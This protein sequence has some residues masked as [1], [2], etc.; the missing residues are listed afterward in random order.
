MDRPDDSPQT[1]IVTLTVEKLQALVREAVQAA[2]GERGPEER[3]LDITEAAQLLD[4]S[5]DWLYGQAKKLPFTRKL[6][7]RVLR[8]S[9]Q[10]LLKWLASRPKANQNG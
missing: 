9:Y 5:E 8:F 7:P 6:A 3:L 1:L 2:L 4:V 10:G